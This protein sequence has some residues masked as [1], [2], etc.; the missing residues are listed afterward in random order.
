MPDKMNVRE[1][2]RYRLVTLAHLT[3]YD[4]EMDMIKT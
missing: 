3:E 1:T 2:T 4:T